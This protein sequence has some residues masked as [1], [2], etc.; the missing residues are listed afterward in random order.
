MSCNPPPQYAFFS[1]LLYPVLYFPAPCFV[2]I[3]WGEVGDL[4]SMGGCMLFTAHLPLSTLIRLI[5]FISCLSMLTLPL[6]FQST[7][8][9]A[10]KG[11]QRGRPPWGYNNNLAA[12][13]L[14]RFAAC[15]TQTDCMCVYSLDTS[16]ENTVWVLREDKTV[17]LEPS[18]DGG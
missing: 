12:L 10:G 1:P 16:S 2:F 11:V 14:M 7:L 15:F 17:A 18:G 6:S 5:I 4:F 13:K 8:R 3:L 9:W